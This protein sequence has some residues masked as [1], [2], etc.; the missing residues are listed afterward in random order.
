M[1]WRLSHLSGAHCEFAVTNSAKPADVAVDCDVVGWVSE[2]ELSLVISK[3]MVISSLIAGIGAEQ[4]V[5]T[6]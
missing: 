3:E 4:S 5:I 6:Q 2:N 1:K